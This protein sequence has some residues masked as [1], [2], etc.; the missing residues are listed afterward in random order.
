M[1]VADGACGPPEQAA[2]EMQVEGVGKAGSRNAVAAVAAT[3]Y[4]KRVVGMVE[5][6][7]EGGEQ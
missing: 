5:V 2:L 4:K 3:A 1:S 6:A 7:G